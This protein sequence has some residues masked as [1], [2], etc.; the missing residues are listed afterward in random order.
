MIYFDPLRHGEWAWFKERTSVIMCEDSKGIVARNEDG[1]IQAICVADSFS[2]DACSVH[3]AIANPFVIRHGFLTAIADWL[4]GQ[5]GRSRIFGLVPSNN[6]K[7]LKLD[8]HIGFEEVAVIPKVL[9][10]NVD[11]VVLCMTREQCRWLTPAL[12][13]AG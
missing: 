3:F 6:K 2:V 7:A 10:E 13:E 1:I 12:K 5:C 4:F 8:K 11:Y 9:A